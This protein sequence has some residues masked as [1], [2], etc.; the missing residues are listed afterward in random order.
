MVFADGLAMFDSGRAFSVCNQIVGIDPNLDVWEGRD[1]SWFCPTDH[2]LDLLNPLPEDKLTA[3]EQI[4]LADYML[5][6]WE[7][8]RK[9]ALL[10]ADFA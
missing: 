6:K 5:D 4:E 3:S 7:E 9:R 10:L 8:F 1:G 2:G